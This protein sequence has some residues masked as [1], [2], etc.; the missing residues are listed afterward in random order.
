[1]I[2]ALIALAVALVFTARREVAPEARTPAQLAA[3]VRALGWRA[4]LYAAAGLAV[5]LAVTAGALAVAACGTA[6]K[7]LSG[8]A[9]VIAACGWH[10]AGLIGWHPVRLREAR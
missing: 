4:P 6:V 2:W 1:M 10:V 5:V 9:L 7:T 8:I 3:A